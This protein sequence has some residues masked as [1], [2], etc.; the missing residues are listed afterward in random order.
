MIDAGNPCKDI[1]P[2]TEDEREIW[3]EQLKDYMRDKD[4]GL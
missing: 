3:K 1:R 2:I 4:I